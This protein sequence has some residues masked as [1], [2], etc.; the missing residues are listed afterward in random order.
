[1]KTIKWHCMQPSGKV[2]YN[3]ALRLDTNGAINMETIFEA[4]KKCNQYEL[5]NTYKAP[6]RR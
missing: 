4:N 3:S 5:K 6:S 1:M 2:F